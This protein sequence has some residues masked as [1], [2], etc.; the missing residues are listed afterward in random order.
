MEKRVRRRI[1]ED[2]LVSDDAT[3]EDPETWVIGLSGGKD[4]VV[5]TQ[6]LHDTF[7]EDPRIELSC[8]AYPRGH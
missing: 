2:G 6:I 8:A 7:A 1:R 3:V 5:L 4:S